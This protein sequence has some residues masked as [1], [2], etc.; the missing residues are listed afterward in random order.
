MVAVLIDTAPVTVKSVDELPYPN[1]GA[2]YN[3]EEQ[4]L[5]IKRG[6]GDSVGLFQC[7]A[8]ELGH[9][10]LSINSETYSRKDMGFQAVCIAYMLC[11]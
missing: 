2:Y 11:R 8:Q 7:V 3:N 10:Q 9:A 6:I 1:M 5:L 4:N